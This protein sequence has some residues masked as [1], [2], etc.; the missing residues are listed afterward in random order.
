L[1]VREL[2]AEGLI[3]KNFYISF[4]YEIDVI[5]PPK[6]KKGRSEVK[7]TLNTP[8]QLL[9]QC[10]LSIPTEALEKEM[11]KLSVQMLIPDTE[12]LGYF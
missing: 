8:T 6:A 9:P 12:S 3:S 4:S 5:C 10:H 1:L 7:W 2:L 11:M